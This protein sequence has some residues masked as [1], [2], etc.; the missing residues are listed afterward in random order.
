MKQVMPQP[1]SAMRSA[2]MTVRP[3]AG[4]LTY[5]GDPPKAPPA[6][7]RTIA[8]INPASTGASE[9]IAIPNDNGSATKENH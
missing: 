9:A 3:A 2:T 7:P 5:S 6:I 4:P 1:N 8:A